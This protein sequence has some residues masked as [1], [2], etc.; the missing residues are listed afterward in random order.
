MKVIKND[1]LYCVG[2]LLGFLVISFV[3]VIFGLC[4]G[5]VCLRN[6]GYSKLLVYVFMF[7]VLFCFCFFFLIMW[8]GFIYFKCNYECWY[9]VS[10]RVFDVIFMY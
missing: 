9:F 4:L 1:I 7:L 8:K 3:C 2:K 6:F 5:F 10:F